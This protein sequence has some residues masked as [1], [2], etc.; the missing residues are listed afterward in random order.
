METVSKRL[1][2]NLANSI[3]QVE[4]LQ[5]KSPEVLVGRNEIGE[6]LHAPRVVS[7][8]CSADVEALDLTHLYESVDDGLG[9]ARVHLNAADVESLQVSEDVSHLNQSYLAVSVEVDM[10]QA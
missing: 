9:C 1:N 7:K 4:A 2:K 10:R 6:A 5:T 8:A 3:C